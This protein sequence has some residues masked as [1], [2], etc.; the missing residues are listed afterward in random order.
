MVKD[1]SRF[2]LFAAV[3]SPCT[4]EELEMQ[5]I[6]PDNNENKIISSSKLNYL[7]EHGVLCQYLLGRK[8]YKHPYL[9]HNFQEKLVRIQDIQLQM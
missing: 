1:E 7:H 3:S 6:N 8:V 4:E 9:H 2:Y 5:M